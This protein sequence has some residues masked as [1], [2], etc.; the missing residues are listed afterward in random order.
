VTFTIAPAPTIAL[1]SATLTF[2]ATQFGANPPSQ[3]ITITNSGGAVLSG[4]NI[5]AISYGTG[6]TGWIQ[7]PILSSTVADPSATLTVQPLTGALVPGTHTATFQVR[8][9]VATNSPRNVTVSLIV[10]AAQ[11]GDPASIEI[12]EGNSQTAPPGS[13]VPIAPKVIVRDGNGT[14]VPGVAVSFATVPSVGSI[15]GA[16]AMTGVDGVA[17]LESWNVAAGP[18]ALSATFSG[19]SVEGSVVFSATGSASSAGFNVELRFTTMPALSQLVAFRDAVIRWESIITGDLPGGLLP[20]P[21]GECFVNSPAIN[22]IVDDLVIIVVLEFIDGPGNTLGT[23]GPCIIR[24]VGALPALGS[25]R[26][27]TADLAA[28]EVDGILNAVILHEM[29]HVLGFGVLWNFPEFNLLVNPSLPSSPGVDTHFSGANAIAGFDL[30]GGTTYTGGMKVP[31]ENSQGGA[32]NRDSHWREN[33][34]VNELM[35]PFIAQGMSSNPLSVLS[36]RSMQDLGYTVNP[37]AADPFFLVLG[38]MGLKEAP[39]GAQLVNDVERRRIY[40]MD[41]RGRITGSI[42]PR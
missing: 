30:I 2:N 42:P 38:M 5:G 8:S 27:D 40:I 6:A 37:D 14:P 22:Q 39:R 1:S 36:V 41:E 18:N 29:G 12:F 21:A 32:G 33:V 9:T 19:Q 3:L 34:L 11:P 13:N 10:G 16:D 25:M 31:V 35:T 20:L 15:T 26:F 28:M 17:T 4:L 24:T 23:A 7:N